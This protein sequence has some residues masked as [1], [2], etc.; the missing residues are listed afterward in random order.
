[1]LEAFIGWRLGGAGLLLLWLA[2]AHAGLA[3][4]F[5][6][7]APALL[8]KRPE[9]GLHPLAV[10]V[11]LPYLFFLWTFFHLKRLFLRGEDCSN[12]VAPGIYVGRRPLA[13]ELPPGLGLVVDLMAEMA[14]SNAALAAAPYVCLP[15][16]NRLVPEDAAFRQ[17]V[18][19][20]AAEPGSLYIHCGAGKGRSATVAAAVLIARGLAPDVE[21][22]VEILQISRPIVHLHP[23]QED[24]VRRFSFSLGA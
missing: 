4:A 18:L 13:G 2:L 24:L 8:G 15:T 16:L 14:E 21:R 11:F 19:R 17:L 9:G 1:L 22:A 10:L 23:V 3:L 20:L 12:E 7:R 6:F 5:F